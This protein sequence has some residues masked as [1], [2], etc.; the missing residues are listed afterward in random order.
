MIYFFLTFLAFLIREE[1]LPQILHV[2]QI[3]Q[4]TLHQNV[5]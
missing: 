2:K 3:L 5:F 4:F 1:S